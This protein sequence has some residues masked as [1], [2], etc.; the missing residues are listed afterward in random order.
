MQRFTTQ[1]AAQI[2]IERRNRE[3]HDQERNSVTVNHGLGLDLN[4][5]PHS[6]PAHM[7][8]HRRPAVAEER[9][10]RQEEQRCN[11]EN[12]IRIPA[13]VPP[14]IRAIPVD[15]RR[16][17]A[18]GGWR[19]RLCPLRGKMLT[20]NGLSGIMAHEQEDKLGSQSHVET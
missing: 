16:V 17:D 12:P 19:R 1:P 8:H 14:F 10:P 5:S 18:P 11:H 7:G 13:R 2:E 4:P 6:S 20:L 15:S 9:Y 3:R